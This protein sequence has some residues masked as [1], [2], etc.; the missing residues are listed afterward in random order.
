MG[1]IKI[2]DSF[3]NLANEESVEDSPR[4][5]GLV[6]NDILK[7]SFPAE[8]IVHTPSGPTCACADHAEKLKRLFSFIGCHVG[9]EIATDGSQCANCW[10]EDDKNQQERI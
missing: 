10:N 5:I 6:P 7:K 4:P 3:G 8:F 1:K 9:T 2:Y